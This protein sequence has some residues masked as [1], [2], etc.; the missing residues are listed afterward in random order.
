MTN[1]RILVTGASGKTGSHVV[2]ELL[3]TGYPVRAMA[4]SNE[5]IARVAAAALSDPARHA[6]K[7]YRP[8]GPALLG[9]EDM[10]QAIGRAVGR[11]VR[12]V[13]TPTWLFMKVARMGGMPIDLISNVRYYIDDH[14]LGAFELAAPTSDVST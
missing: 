10:A 6:G 1:P 8:A 12:V 9:A 7:T 4:P 3:K 11:S 5:D 13:P 2:A 14:K